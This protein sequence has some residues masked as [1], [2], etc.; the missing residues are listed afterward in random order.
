MNSKDILSFASKV[1]ITEGKEVIAQVKNLDRNFLSAVEMLKN[2]EGK[3]VVVGVGK[4]GLIGR[5]LSATFSSINIPSVFLHPVELLHG[6][7]GAI[8]TDDIVLLLS[9]SG[10]TEEIKKV[11]P[12]LRNFK[13]KVIAMTGQKSSKLAQSC[14][15]VINTRI[16]KEACPYNIVPTSST[17]AML[18][19]GDALALTAA[20]LRGFKKEDLFSVLQ[21]G[22]FI[23]FI[24]YEIKYYFQLYK[25]LKNFSTTKNY[26]FSVAIANFSAPA[27]LHLSII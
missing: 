12:V 27:N 25:I 17:T 3:L 1:I 23:L 9:Y 10:E 26:S 15:I 5:K 21:L 24:L 4:S 11:L 2:L 20:K 6:D 22:H 18:A 8:K 7:L 16:R 13:V 14:D 19:V